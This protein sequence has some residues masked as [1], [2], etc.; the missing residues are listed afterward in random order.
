[1]NC[2][3]LLLSIIIIK[4]H[5]EVSAVRGIVHSGGSGIYRRR[6]HRPCKG[7]PTLHTEKF[8]LKRIGTHRGCMP[9]AP[10][11]GFANGAYPMQFK[12]D[13]LPPQLQIKITW[14]IE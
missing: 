12:L 4:Q 9:G 14:I 5:L 6:G 7:L 3:Q 13:N 2:L 8:V 10:P 11:L 1:M